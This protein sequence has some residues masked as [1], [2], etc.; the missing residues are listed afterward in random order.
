MHMHS[1]MFNTCKGVLLGDH[2]LL[3]DRL[4]GSDMHSQAI[5]IMVT[6]RTAW[7][8]GCGKAPKVIWART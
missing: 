3:T 6:R 7:S 2:S 1:F 8:S 5:L 4:T